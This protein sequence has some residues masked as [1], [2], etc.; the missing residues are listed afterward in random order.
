[1]LR[2]ESLEAARILGRYRRLVMLGKVKLPL[3]AARRLVGP[4]CA[5]HLYHR[6]LQAQ[7]RRARTG[8]QAG[9]ASARRRSRSG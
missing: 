5:Y 3:D 6:H 8:S 7:R 2:R 9:A 1:M 4:D